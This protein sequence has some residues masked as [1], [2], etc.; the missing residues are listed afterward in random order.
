MLTTEHDCHNASPAAR[1]QPKLENQDTGEL[2]P[3][4][5]LDKVTSASVPTLALYHR[6]VSH[7]LGLAAEE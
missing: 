4:R 2:I 6:K 3:Q 5:Y 1:A 7:L